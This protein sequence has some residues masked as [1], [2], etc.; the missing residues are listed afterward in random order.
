MKIKLDE[1]LPLRL[2]AGL[3]ALGHEVHTVF[4]EDLL[5]AR[6]ERIWAVAQEEERF[7]VTQDL[8]FADLRRFVPGT[9]WSP[10]GSAALPEPNKL[11][12]SNPRIVSQRRRHFVAALLCGRDRA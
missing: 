8:D 4:D 9:P 12:Q 3:T 10:S 1:N 5:G 2:A 11:S 7:L 6:D